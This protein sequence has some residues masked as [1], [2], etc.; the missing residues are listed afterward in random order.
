MAED[1]DADVIRLEQ[2]VLGRQAGSGALF[3]HLTDGA[4]GQIKSA[5]CVLPPR[6]CVWCAPWS[7]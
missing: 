7:H 3:V 4:W 6:R 1:R 2:D 5:G